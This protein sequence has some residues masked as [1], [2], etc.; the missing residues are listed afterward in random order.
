MYST[1]GGGEISLCYLLK[2]LDRK[3]F[4]PLV[5]VNGYGPL[6]DRLEKLGI[7]V[8]YVPFRKT[9][10]VRL[11]IPWTFG[12]NLRASLMLR[13][14]I[15]REKVNLVHCADLFAL[16][17]LLPSLLC[18][19]VRVVYQAII[20]YHRVQRFALRLFATKMV[21]RIVANSFAVRESLRHVEA[22]HRKTIPVIHC[23]V[24]TTL[25]HPFTD[26]ERYQ[27]RVRWNIPMAKSIIGLI[28]RYDIW[29][30]HAT[31]LH[32]LHLLREQRADVV[33]ILVG[34][35]ITEL[36]HVRQY[37]RHIH[38]MI[39]QLSISDIVQDL[40]HVDDIASV[41]PALDAVVCPSDREPFGM[42]V[43]EGYA[44]GIPVVTTR[45][46][47]ALEV[48]EDKRYL[49]ICDPNDPQALARAIQNALRS[50]RSKPL[51]KQL[52]KLSWQDYVRNFEVQ[53]EQAISDSITV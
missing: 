35:P 24:D 22:F 1:A 48:L 15:E 42:V 18:H 16:V 6:V 28:A 11:I 44:C 31:F 12:Q 23:G 34:G 36:P 17:L 2:G 21:K 51:E 29:K 46:V 47:G 10:I 40:G 8:L 52:E 32:A 37:Q 38:R 26:E 19:R 4:T 53:Y 39:Q 9:H 49:F 25:F 14:I 3:R 41:Y 43:L 45:A 50:P 13:Q 30:G 20:F 5:V 7:R 27:A 33:A